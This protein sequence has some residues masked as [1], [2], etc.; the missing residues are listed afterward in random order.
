VNAA[1]SADARLVGAIPA[2]FV[3]VHC[4]FSG[5]RGYDFKVEPDRRQFT[6]VPA[7]G[8][9]KPQV[10]LEDWTPSTIINNGTGWNHLEIAC[11]GDSIA[12]SING[13]QVATAHDSTY[14]QGNLFI[15]V[16]GAGSVLPI[17]ARFANLVVTRP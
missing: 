9:D 1:L 3:A 11:M 17:D 2:R 4:R 14:A 12:G 8:P 5:P 7:E 10:T 6:L 13:V 15:S 16:G